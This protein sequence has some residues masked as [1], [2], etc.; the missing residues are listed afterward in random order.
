MMSAK[1]LQVLLAVVKV[2]VKKASISYIS[3]CPIVCNIFCFE[4]FIQ[5]SPESIS[6]KEEKSHRQ[7]SSRETESY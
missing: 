2:S 1:S 6:K 7:I 4:F 3:E 5:Y